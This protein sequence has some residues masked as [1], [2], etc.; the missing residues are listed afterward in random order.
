MAEAL[1]SVAAV[2]GLADVVFRMC[3][4]LYQ[5]LMSLKEVPEQVNTLSDSLLVWAKVSQGIKSIAQQYEA[6]PFARADGLSSGALCDALYS[7]QT[8]CKTIEV[9]VKGYREAQAQSKLKLLKNIKW[10]FNAKRLRAALAG[11]EQAKLSL[12]LTLNA[13]N[14]WL[15]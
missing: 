13:I 2:I 10:M 9:L 1:S 12:N 4:S 6:S 15:P 7:C 3:R 8:V 14:R 5:D 11:L